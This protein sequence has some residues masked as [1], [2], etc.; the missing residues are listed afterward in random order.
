MLAGDMASGGG[1]SVV[2]AAGAAAA[3]KLFREKSSGYL[4]VLADRLSRGQAKHGVGRFARL[5]HAVDEG[6]EAVKA[7]TGL[8]AHHALNEA[9][10]GH[11]PDPGAGLHLGARRAGIE[12][13]RPGGQGSLESVFGA[14]E[15]LPDVPLEV[16]GGREAQEVMG[17]LQRRQLAV[18]NAEEEAGPNPAARAR[19][20]QE[21]QQKEAA[22]LAAEA[23]EYDTTQWSG[24]P[25]TALQK[26]VYRPALLDQIGQ[27]ISAEAQAAPGPAPVELEEERVRELT[28]D[29]DGPAAIGGLQQTF[30][31]AIEQAP[32]TPEGAVIREGLQQVRQRLEEADVPQAIIEGHGAVEALR[33]AADQLIDPVAKSYVHRQAMA[34]EQALSSESLGSFGALYAH[35]RAPQT[36][37]FK[38]LSDPEKAREFLRGADRRGTLA[39]IVADQA[40]TAARASEAAAALSGKTEGKP[41]VALKARYSEL[42]DRFAA[43]EDAVLLDG[44]PA[45]RVADYFLDRPG[46]RTAKALGQRPETLV[47]NAVRP[48]IEQLIPVLR[49]DVKPG[50]RA[51]APAPLSREELVSQHNARI[52]KL[53]QAGEG[54][55]EDFM[56]DALSTLPIDDETRGAVSIEVTETV[57]QLAQNMPRIQR[58]WR[59]QIISGLSDE[60]LRM[61]NAIWEGTT[62]P[63]SI[64]DDFRHGSVDPD[65]VAYVHQNS[66]GLIEAA[67][68][69]FIDALTG[70]MTAEQRAQISDPVLTQLDSLLGFNGALQPTNAPDW[71]RSVEDAVAQNIAE[72]DDQAKGQSGSLNLSAPQSLTERL[73]SGGRA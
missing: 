3:H 14:R 1:L 64:I 29:A 69:G 28:G 52:D 59:G 31:Q 32:A 10:I 4:A 25:P 61:S 54:M 21:A 15:T 46:A 44:G 17:A 72:E 38:T 30:D 36:E 43:A 66:P 23:G 11:H 12:L 35:A 37:A 39:A 26:I 62:D 65:K 55:G 27:D 49:G 5:G 41:W 47:A 68:A 20:R 40:D 13:S 9:L 24:K 58:D 51:K 71:I 48:R 53:E 2:K 34:L 42:E 63:L 22:G 18:T 56:A 73:A 70:H 6:K 57:S 19:A 60:D 8:D 50:P 33:G 45:K 7:W 67:Q 16:A